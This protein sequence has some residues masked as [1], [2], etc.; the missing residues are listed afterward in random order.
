MLKHKIYDTTTAL[1][2]YGKKLKNKI[3]YSNLSNYISPGFGNHK[4]LIE[5]NKSRV[6]GPEPCVCHAASRSIYFDIYGNAT[7]CC[8]N[9]VYILGKYPKNSI[10]EIIKGDKRKKL[11]TELCRQNFMYGCQ[12]CHKLIEAGNYE[13]VEARLYDPLRNQGDTPS[14]IIF[15]LDNTCNLECVMCHEG[16]S[17]SIAK[18]KGLEKIKHPYDKDF[19][20]QIEPYIKNLEVAKFLGGEPFL[21]NIYY[22]IWDLIIKTNPKCKIIL[23]TNGTILNDKVKSYLAKGNFYIGVSIDSLKPEIFERIRVNAKL[24][25]VLK[26]LDYFI[27]VTKKKN[28]YVNLSV[29]PMQNNWKEMPDLVN[30][31][32]EKKIFIYFN[33]VYT[34][35]FA[36]S[37]MSEEELLEI[38]NYYESVKFRTK[39]IIAKRNVR[40]FN[41]LKTQIESIYF[42]KFNDGL[43]Y[44]KRHEFSSLQLKDKL[45]QLTNKDTEILKIIEQVFDFEEKEFMLSDDN[46]KNLDNLTTKDII[47]VVR[48]ESIEQI[49]SRIFQFIDIGKFGK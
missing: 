11:Q 7:A 1:S 40:F 31:C 21:I 17:S 33:T 26:N 19:L 37:Q 32:N 47:D 23:Q 49:Q 46:L 16:F 43:H 22:E 48:T 29:C 34:D 14:E 2:R 36:I 24:D 10:E 6:T 13:G 25:A 42:E 8:F 35:G 4:K 41:N 27:S 30:F 12:H 5:Y 18:S 15:E 38:K 45:L 44:K 28:N 3:K 20:N 9:R 39:G